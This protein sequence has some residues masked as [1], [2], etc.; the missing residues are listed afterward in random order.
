VS[1]GLS[2]PYQVD[3]YQIQQDM[4]KIN[5]LPN[6]TELVL[7][8]STDRTDLAPLLKMLR[9]R[10]FPLQQYHYCSILKGTW[11][12]TLLQSDN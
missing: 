7:T 8:S 6:K 10:F 5:S 9:C 12:E 1:E 2:V 11:G 3:D 4:M